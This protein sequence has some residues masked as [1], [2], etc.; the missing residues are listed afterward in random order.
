MADA[1]QVVALAGITYRQ[2]DHWTRQGYVTAAYRGDAAGSG[3]PRSYDVDEVAV[4]VIMA[5]LVKSLDVKPASAA[6]W[7]AQLCESGVVKVG[8]FVVCDVGGRL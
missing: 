7:A 3:V 2:L 4:V 8:R 6:R 5:A 1:D